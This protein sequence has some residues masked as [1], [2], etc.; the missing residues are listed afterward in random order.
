MSSNP[1]EHPHY[2]FPSYSPGKD[3]GVSK[4][5]DAT[6]YQSMVGSLLYAAIAT[7]PD[8]AQAVGVVAK[9]CSKPNEAHMTYFVLPQRHSRPWSKVCQSENGGSVGYSDAD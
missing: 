7:R 2:D 4:D 6:M 8:I 9:Y 5:M 1:V 3:D